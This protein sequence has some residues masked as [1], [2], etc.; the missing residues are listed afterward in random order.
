MKNFMMLTDGYKID[1]RRQYPK[2]TTH[3]LSNFTS[4]T[5]RIVDQTVV[6]FVGLQYVLK[7]YFSD[8]TASEVNQ[9]FF[10]RPK[11][12]VCQEYR[13]FTDQYLPG[14]DIDVDHIAS[15][16]DLGFL[17]L[18]FRALPEGT[19][20]PLRVP[21]F[22]VENT[23][24]DFFWLTNYFEPLISS[25]LWLPCTSAATALRYRRI[26]NDA[27]LRTTGSVAGVEWQAHDFSFRGM[28]GPEAA[29]LSGLGHL[30]A[31]TGTDNLPALELIS[32]Y[33]E[34]GCHG[35]SVPAT[36]HAVMCA[37]GQE[38]ELETFNKLLDLYP[39]GIFSVVS[40]TWDLWHVIT[41][42][43]PALK[44]RIMSRDGK[45]VV[46]PD[47]GDPAD[48][49]CGWGC[50][51]GPNSKPTHRGAVQLLWDIFGGTVNDCGYKVLDSHIGAIY[52]DSITEERAR[53]ITARLEAKG[54]AST[55]V[56]FGV[57]SYT[58][59]YVTR[60]TNG[61]AIKATW[62]VVDNVER[63]LHKNPV[64]DSGVKK[65]AKGRLVVMRGST[66]LELIDGLSQAEHDALDQ[67]N[68]LQPVYR[69]GELLIEQSI[70]DIRIRIFPAA[71]KC[72]AP[73][74]DGESSCLSLGH[75]TM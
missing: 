52:G 18:E 23:H 39:T 74:R 35:G 9:W 6:P 42:I 1:H 4:R 3:V 68:L 40:D 30:V 54:F 28:A 11:D 66:G 34:L 64:T 62:A 57:G 14:N 69:N 47:S 67:H 49:L 44:D 10:H 51:V 65:S 13:K 70:T 55:N 61:F 50:P 22:T 45:L 2:G 16:H 56:V 24:P 17:P 72:R 7:H 5:S 25:L 59:Q 29:A 41:K 75:T 32:E 36:E 58:Y 53:D 43:L 27:A 12:K 31:F 21:M 63:Q 33:Y 37:G 73:Y 15:L 20:T 46:R 60:D 8:R 19:L 38:G 71:A 48:I 26:L